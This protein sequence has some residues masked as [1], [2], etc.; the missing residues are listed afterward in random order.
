MKKSIQVCLTAPFVHDLVNRL[1]V[2]VGHC[3]LLS[4]HR[5]GRLQCAK[6]V[7]AI[8]EIAREIAK[9]VNEYQ[10]LLSESARSAGTQNRDAT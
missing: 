4:D 2:I 9:K 7:S 8:Q 1:A 6:H 10:C 3:G 5:K